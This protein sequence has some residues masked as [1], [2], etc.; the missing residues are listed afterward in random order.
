[1]FSK[2]KTVQLKISNNTII[3]KQ[4]KSEQQ[5]SKS[6][7]GEKE[8]PSEQENILNYKKIRH[9]VWKCAQSTFDSRA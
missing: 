7:M 6:P 1:M 9:Y 2:L 5:T 3:S 4:L 8:H